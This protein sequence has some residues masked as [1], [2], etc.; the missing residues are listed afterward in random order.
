MS[1]ARDLANAGTALTT[2]SATEL[3][4]LDGVTSAV[5]T[6]LDAKAIPANV[7]NNTLADAKG[8]LITAT[9]DNTPARLAV[10]NNGDTLV[11]DSSTS[12]GLRYTEN[13]AAGKNKIINGAFDVW[14][15]GTSITPAT[16]TNGV[17]VADR[18]RWRYNGS[19]VT[20]TATQQIFTPGTAPVAGYESNFFL[21]CATSVAGSGSTANYISQPIEDVRT[22]AG[23]TLTVSFWAK[24]NSGT[25]S[26]STN[27]IQNFGSGGS[28]LVLGTAQTFTATTT[29]TRYTFTFSIASITGKTVG[30][31]SLLE[32]RINFPANTVMELDLWG[33]QVEAGSVA[34]A[35]QTATGTIQGELA[36]C[37]RYYFRANYLKDATYPTYSTGWGT[38]TTATYQLTNLPVAMRTKPASIDYSSVARLQDGAGD[39][40]FTSLAIDSAATTATVG[41]FTTSGSSG[42]TQ[43]RFYWFRGNASTSSY[44]AFSA[45]L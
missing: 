12:T 22:F 37:Q 19:G 7:V 8:D 36:A 14:Q 15:R 17:Y 21:R 41:A 30:T 29:W 35:F 44:I 13:Y 40:A 16:S 24:V 42:L 32:L 34:T 4:Y 45:E 28:S 11:A 3:G 43:S 10:G 25:Q 38:S 5:Q 23:Q 20:N 27:F 18:F 6:Q 9:A 1:K 33:V 26:C 39:Y 2:V 31:S